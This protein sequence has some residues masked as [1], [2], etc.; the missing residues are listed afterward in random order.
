MGK[1]HAFAFHAAPQI[2]D[3]PLTPELAVLADVNQARQT[4]RRGARLRQRG[5]RLARAGGRPRGRRRRDHRAER[6]PQADRA[7]RAQGRQARLLREAARRR[8]LADA[9]EMVEAARAS[10]RDDR[11]SASTTSRT[12]SS[13]SP[14]RSSTAARSASWSPSAASTP[15]TTWSTRQAPHTLR[16]RSG[17]R[18]RADRDLG[19]HI[20]SLARHLVGPIEEVSAATGTLHKTRPSADGPRPV[21]IDD[22]SHVIAR[23]AN[24]VQGTITASW[25][26]PG[27]KMQLEFELVGYARLGRLQRRAVQRAASLH[28]RSER[29]AAG[30]QDA[31]RRPRHAALREF[32]PGAGPPA[33]LQ[34]PEDHRG[35]APDQGDCRQGEAQSGF[36]GSL[37]DPAHRHGRALQS[38]KERSWVRVDSL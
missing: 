31:A 16:T 14:A 25:V 9:K 4:R 30:L 5:R 6:A 3:L 13:G 2:F 32:L 22:H 8:T 34:R 15:R 35:R 24:G 20:I 28:N 27:R 12:R 29:R 36:R 1:A 23:F 11:S 38:A 7:R 26:T 21:T 33:R 19:S 10:G 37:R 17:R 18:R